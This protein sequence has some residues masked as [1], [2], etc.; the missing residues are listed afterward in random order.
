MFSSFDNDRKVKKREYLNLKNRGLIIISLIALLSS[1]HWTLNFLKYSES[2][3]D[4]PSAKLLSYISN[5][6]IYFSALPGIGTAKFVL[7][8][9]VHYLNPRRVS[10]YVTKRST[11]ERRL[12]YIL[13]KNSCA[14]IHLNVKPCTERLFQLEPTVQLKKIDTDNQFDYYLPFNPT[15]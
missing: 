10:G 5:D 6:D 12:L 15:K 11:P 2:S 7:L 4:V 1:I 14:S 13:P 9:D 8:G 3:Y